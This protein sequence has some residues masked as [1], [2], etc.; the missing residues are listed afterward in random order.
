MDEKEEQDDKLNIEIPPGFIVFCDMDGTLVDT[1]YANYLSYRR[2]IVEE[3]RGVHDVHF[4]GERFNEESLKNQAPSLTD[5]QRE[6]IANLK[7]EYFNEF[8][9]ETRLNTILANF[10]RK[11]NASTEIVLVTNCRKRRAMETLRFHNVIDLF[12]ERIYR[13]DGSSNKYERALMLTGHHP[14]AVIVFE[15]GI[16]DIEN[17]VLAGVP[18]RNII[19]PVF[20][21]RVLES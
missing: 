15:N 21:S 16:S 17:A 9:S 5:N 20:G 14:C 2:A 1:D 19:S 11:I 12:A 7:A 3:T 13:E 4:S 6:N 8:L 10:I 18:R